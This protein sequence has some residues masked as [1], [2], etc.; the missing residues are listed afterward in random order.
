MSSNCRS[1]RRRRLCFRQLRVFFGKLDRKNAKISCAYGQKNSCTFGVEKIPL[2]THIFNF[3]A[4]LRNEFFTETL[5]NLTQH[6]QIFT[7]HLFLRNNFSE[8]L[9]KFSKTAPSTPFSGASRP[10]ILVECVV[11]WVKKS[12][13]CVVGTPPRG[14]VP[15]KKYL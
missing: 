15:P 5:K 12:R 1:L 14:R 13:F 2:Y 11:L 7:F 10:K 8:K 9:Q 4:V 6:T 3:V